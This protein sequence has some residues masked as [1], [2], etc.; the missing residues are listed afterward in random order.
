MDTP[1]TMEV[2]DK[3]TYRFHDKGDKRDPYTFTNEIKSV[4]IT[5]AWILGE[6]QQPNVPPKYVWRYDLKRAGALERFEFD[7]AA[8][9]GAGKRTFDGPKNDDGYQFP[10]VVGKKF[11]VKEHWNDGNGYTEYKAEVEAFE[12]VTVEAG[13]F[14]AFRIKYSGWWTCTSGGTGSGRAERI[15]WYS[16][17]TKNI[18]KGEAFDRTPGNQIWNLNTSELVKWEPAPK[19]KSP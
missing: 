17:V 4:D 13:T 16:P 9:N 6:T 15:R 10:L 8:P 18:V 2:G 12:K 19:A 14:D 5:S 1:P 11:T 7:P 3:W